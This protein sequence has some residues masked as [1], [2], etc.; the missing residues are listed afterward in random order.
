MTEHQLNELM[1]NLKHASHREAG[2]EVE[3][4]LIAAFRA[5]HSQNKRL[6]FS[7]KQLAAS[8][9]I[10]A[11][12]YFAWSHRPVT[13]HPHSPAV[14]EEAAF[15]A[16]PY[17]ESGVPLE[18]SVIVRMRIPASTLVSLGMRLSVP[19]E[20][21]VNAELLVGQDGVARAVRIVQ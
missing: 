20:K 8:L 9:A 6:R 10:G 5:R 11:L 14:V 17:A 3:A 13:P 7:W 18:Q 21:S 19:P 12:L 1:R 2:Q 4:E 15:F 16:L